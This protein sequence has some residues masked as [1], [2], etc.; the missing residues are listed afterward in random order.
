MHQLTDKTRQYEESILNNIDENLVLPDVIDVKK[1]GA[2]Y[3]KVGIPFIFEILS[4]RKLGKKVKVLKL[5][6]I[7]LSKNK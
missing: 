6:N 1:N 7:A 4:Y 2:C 5:F 3:K